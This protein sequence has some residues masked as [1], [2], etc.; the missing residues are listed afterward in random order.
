MLKPMVAKDDKQ[1]R[2]YPDGKV[3][4]K[5]VGSNIIELYYGTDRGGQIN[6]W[7]SGYKSLEYIWRPSDN[8]KWHEFDQI[9]FMHWDVAAIEYDR[10][11]TVRD[12]LDLVRRNG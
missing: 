6:I 4:R 11:K 2:S 12:I 9:S 3:K 8:K 10:L 1:W 5:K 7:E